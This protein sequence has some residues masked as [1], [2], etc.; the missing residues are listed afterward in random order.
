MLAFRKILFL[1]FIAQL[2]ISCNESNNNDRKPVYIN[3]NQLDEQLIEAN[4][5]VIHS[6]LKQIDDLVARYGWDM[7]ITGTG[8][9]YQVYDS[10]GGMA[11]SKGCRVSMQ[12]TVKLIN[13]TTVYHWKQEGIKTFIAGK[14]EVVAG[15]EEAILFLKNNDK[16]RIIIPSFLGH[17]L[18]G[19]G[20]KIPPKATM[21]YDIKLINVEK[22]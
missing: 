17:G 14:G 19:D 11:V 9:R 12:Y 1:A 20:N 8:L 7:I 2:L 16:A 15:L 13:G 21:I 6:E 5:K 3:K 4:K 22:L 18:A 10:P